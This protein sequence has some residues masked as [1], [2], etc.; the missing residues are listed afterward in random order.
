MSD[1]RAFTDWKSS[2]LMNATIQSEQQIKTDSEY[3]QYLQKNGLQ[4]FKQEPK[5]N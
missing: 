2:C 5:Q 4:A 1:G 3:R